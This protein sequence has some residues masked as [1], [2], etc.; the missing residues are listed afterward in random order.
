MP[1]NYFLVRAMFR[2]R[3]T[4]L[5]VRDRRMREVNQAIQ[6]IKVRFSTPSTPGVRTAY[7][8]SPLVPLTVHQILCLGSEMGQQD[9]GGTLARD[10]LLRKSKWI[11]FLMAF[12]WGRCP[13]FRQRHQL[14]ELCPYRKGRAYRRDCVPGIDGVR[15]VDGITNRKSL[16][17][18]EYLRSNL[19][20][21]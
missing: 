4:L 17:F 19:C 21:A 10:D 5:D 1:G 18:R 16:M 15:V 13:S 2:L 20:V 8:Y 3:K 7:Q 11:S 14:H 9:H 6:A 12:F